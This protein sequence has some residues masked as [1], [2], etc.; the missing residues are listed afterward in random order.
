MSGA[1][2]FDRDMR[3]LR[4]WRAASCPVQDRRHLFRAPGDHRFDTAVAAIAHPAS[5]A[6]RLRLAR[7]A[8]AVADAL[9]PT[10]DEQV[11]DF[12]Y[13]TCMPAVAPLSGERM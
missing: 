11:P 9:H 6:E 13:F 2:E 12:H 8:G 7:H 1:A 4:R 5:D 3:H 10:A